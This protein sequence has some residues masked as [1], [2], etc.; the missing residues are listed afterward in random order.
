MNPSPWN[1]QQATAQLSLGK[2]SGTLDV[3]R[4]Q[5]GLHAMHFAGQSLANWS[6]WNVDQSSLGAPFD[7]Y[8]R[9]HDLVATY[10]RTVERPLRVQIYWRALPIMASPAVTGI[11]MIVSVQTDLLDLDPQVQLSSCMTNGA[12][13]VADDTVL[14]RGRNSEMTAVHLVH[15]GDRSQVRVFP[16]AAHHGA[17]IQT[18]LFADRLEKGVILR[19]RLRG[20]FMDRAN[21]EATAAE[22][23]RHFAASEPPLTA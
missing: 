6:L 9:D 19:S 16:N 5:L 11:E 20:F 21:D 8:V 3:A 17:D 2:F 12:A 15:P 4:P 13:Q 14:F 10:E 1:L 7:V 22:L 23:A 18:T